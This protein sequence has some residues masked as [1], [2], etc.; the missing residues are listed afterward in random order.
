VI[1]AQVF[2]KVIRAAHENGS[3]AVSMFVSEDPTFVKILTEGVL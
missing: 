1:A 3:A 2:L